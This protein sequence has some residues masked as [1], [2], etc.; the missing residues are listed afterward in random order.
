MPAAIAA[1]DRGLRVAL[2]EAADRL[3]GA[4][5]LSSASISAAGTSIQAAAGVEDDPQAHF[6]DCLRINHGTGDHALIRRW[7]DGAAAMVEWLVS[8]GWTCTPEQPV[9]APEHEL[10]RTK[11]T[12]CSSKRGQTLLEAFVPLIERHRQAGRIALYLDTRFTS[13]LTERGRVCGITARRGDETIALRSPD[14]LLTTGGYSASG[15]ML[16]QM[17]GFAPLRY[18]CPTALGEGLRA[19]QRLGGVVR[20]ADHA[21]PTF[22]ATRDLGAHS[23]AW[24]AS[25]ILPAMR[26]PWEIYLNEHGVRFMAEDEAGMDRRE[27]ALSNQPGWSFWVVYDQ[28]ILDQAP[29]LLLREQDKLER[30]FATDPDYVVAADLAQLSARCNLPHDAVRRSV[31]RYNA[32]QAVGS[33]MLGRQHMPLPIAQPP[34]Y[35]VHHYGVSIC[36]AGGLAVNHDLAVVREDGSVIEGLHAAG[37]VL[38]SGFL[39][40]AFLSGSVLSC[41]ITFG[42]QLGQTIGADRLQVA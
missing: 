37:E 7:T 39:G 32:G 2:I 34:F 11:R 20:F 38:G 35:A 9:F 36:S 8:I 29:K 33:D 22:G 25:A 3:G 23:S 17:H 14:V 13:F 27:R 6:A 12:Y 24:I 18:C 1:A 26:Q 21:L 10:Y 40:H 4:L 42:R 16:E 41:A 15:E 28:A 19:A 31:D 5:F 30:L